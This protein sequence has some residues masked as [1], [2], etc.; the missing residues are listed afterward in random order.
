MAR[1]SHKGRRIYLGS[2]ATKALAD[3][4]CL[5]ERARIDLGWDPA[6]DGRFK[7]TR[8]VSYNR[9]TGL[10]QVSI[11]TNGKRSWLGAYETQKKALQVRDDA[12]K[13][14]G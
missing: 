12:K 10:W 8:G 2:Y 13:D 6:N 1:I 11:T 9:V 14:K 5:D 4:A 7:R 3:D